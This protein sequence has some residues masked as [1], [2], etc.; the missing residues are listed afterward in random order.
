[1]PCIHHSRVIDCPND[2]GK[3]RPRCHAEA[4]RSRS[5]HYEDGDDLEISSLGWPRNLSHNLRLVCPCSLH[6][7]IRGH[8]KSTPGV[9][10]SASAP[11]LMSRVSPQSTSSAPR[12]MAMQSWSQSATKCSQVTK[13]IQIDATVPSTTPAHREPPHQVRSPGQQSPPN[14]T[15]LAC[16]ARI[17]DESQFEYIGQLH[18]SGP[19]DSTNIRKQVDTAPTAS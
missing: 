13:C 5:V 9:E 19:A 14:G 6:A 7:G 16:S 12:M 10:R 2:R 18:E 3:L 8:S 17:Q 11:R 15:L 1:M 4:S